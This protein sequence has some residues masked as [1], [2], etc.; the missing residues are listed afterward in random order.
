MATYEIEQDKNEQN[1]SKQAWADLMTPEQCKRGDYYSTQYFIRSAEI[2]KYKEEWDAITKL[3]ECEREPYED[4]PDYP[5]SMIPIMLPTIEGQV[6]SMMESKIDFRHITNTPS[7]RPYMMK[8]DAASE[9]YRKKTKFLQHFKDCTRGYEI[10]GNSWVYTDWQEGHSNRKSQPKGYPKVQSLG[11]DSVLVDGAIK[12]AKDIQEARYIIHVIGNVPIYDARKEYGDEYADALLA[13]YSPSSDDDDVSYDDSTTFTLLHVWTRQNEYGNL[14]LIE[15]DINGLILRESD[16]KEPY[17][18]YV[19][20]EYPFAMIRMMPH[21]GK[22]Y[23]FGDGKVLKPIQETINKLTDELELAARFSSQSHLFVDPDSR[24]A[25]GQ[26]TSNPADII[27]AKQPRENILPVPAQGINPVIQQ[28]IAYLMQVAQQA[29]RFHDIMTGNQEGVSATA[30]QINT[31]VVQGS[32]GIRDKKTDIAEVMAWADMYALK[33][34]LEFWDKPFWASIGDTG[35]EY[36]DVETMIELPAAMPSGASALDQALDMIKSGSEKI[37]PPKFD[38]IVDEDGNDV[39]VDADF[40]T[41]VIIGEAMPRG[42]TDMYNILLGLSQIQI[43]NKE[44]GAIEPLITPARMREAIEDI[45]GMKLRTQDEELNEIKEEFI[46]QNLQQMN[47]IGQGDTIQTP[48]AQMQM[49]PENLQ[50]TV[51]QMPNG[52]SRRVQL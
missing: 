52:D 6:A 26:I 10:Y 27:Y 37:M 50:Q 21:F 29:T 5:N 2:A 1:G 49:T 8:Y 48:Q 40:E 25:E 43:L 33:L 3:Y 19:D 38:G 32:V 24:M 16:P 7:H 35:S 30:T 18:K 46:Q 14:Q 45:L 41:K 20:N 17:Y 23:G 39:Y 11:L 36:V 4:D 47:P 22:F 44:T 51:P 31:Q 12:D 42:R 28:M 15:M 13:G 9:Y 34:C